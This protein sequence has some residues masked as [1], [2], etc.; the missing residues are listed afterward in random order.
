MKYQN[1]RP[2]TFLER[3]NRFIAKVEIDG[4]PETVHVKN[5][6]RLAELFVPGA[7]VYV[8]EMPDAPGRKTRWDL[9]AVKKGDQLINVDS[10]APNAV[11]KEWLKEGGLFPDLTRLCP[12]YTWGDSRFDFYLETADGR[13]IFLEV[14]G[15]TLEDD[16]VVLFPDAPSERAVK[17]VQ[18]LERALQEGYEAYILFVI[19]ME[20]ARY[21]TPNTKAQP[22]FAETL[23]NASDTGVKVLAFDC[24]VGPDTL[25][26]KEEIPVV[27]G[28]PLLYEIRDPLCTWYRENRRDLPWRR[29]PDAYRVWVSEI[30]LQ[31][32]RVEAVKPY[33]ER[34]L[35]ELPDVRHLAEV[36][37]DRLLKLWEGLGYYNRARNMQKAARQIMEEYGGAFPHTYEEIRTLCGIGDYTAGAIASFA[38]GLPEPAVDGNV[39]RVVAR[40]TENEAD[41]LKQSTK[42][43]IEEELKR[44]IPAACPGDFNQGLIELGALICLPQAEPKCGQCPL[45][46]LCRTR[47]S[48]RVA[49]IPVRR[50]P[51]ERR[52][53]EKTILYLRDG[54]KVA[55]RKRDPQ[56]LLAG[57][58][59]LP[60]LS[61]H[62]TQ[63]EVTAY[64]KSIGLMPVRLKKMPAAKHIFTH[65]EWHMIGYEVWVDELEKTN[66]KQFL[67]IRPDE[68]REKYPIPSAFASYL[69]R[70]GRGGS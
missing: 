52:I 58:Y 20:N 12:E 70:V 55:I 35:K 31:Q 68:I 10:Q 18:G 11:V 43:Q 4:Q 51:K 37:E 14:K 22:V 62:L 5:T 69:P 45:A 16:G 24:E 61:G 25:Q 13:K 65:V 29:N 50:K 46:R 2:G 26:I 17:H 3:S 9:I 8:Q 23:K 54:E 63:K 64:L 53:E 27:L 56:G 7:L 44:V 28:D 60:N 38:C 67:F 48:G 19:Q 41:I 33:Y 6:G 49:E 34:F 42:K 32:T 39:L 21:F 47:K 66:D 15:V 36:S 59:E 57:M 30:M 40:L 1:I